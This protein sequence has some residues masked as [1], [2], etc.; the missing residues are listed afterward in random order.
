LGIEGGFGVGSFQSLLGA[1]LGYAGGL[2]IDYKITDIISVK[3]GINYD[4]KQAWDNILVLDSVQEPLYSANI[5]HSYEFLNMPIL[6]NFKFGNK[7]SYYVN[8]GPYFAFLLKQTMLVNDEILNSTIETENTDSYRRLEI[9]LTVGAGVLIPLND[10]FG[11]SLGLRNNLGLN[12]LSKPEGSTF[13]T[14]S[15]L[16]LAGLVIKI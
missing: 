7:I 5:K 12:S 2:T 1:G 9:G 14:N 15:T 10:K 3:T 16:L 13:K 4:Y 8:A 6:M 11:L